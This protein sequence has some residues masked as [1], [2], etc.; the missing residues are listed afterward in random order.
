MEKDFKFIFFACCAAAILS[1]ISLP[2]TFIPRVK[3]FSEDNPLEDISDTVSIESE[4]ING[5]E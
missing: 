5:L 3:L 1:L 4:V 2:F